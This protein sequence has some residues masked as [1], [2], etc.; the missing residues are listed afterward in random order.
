MLN[1]RT[2]DP[3]LLERVKSWQDDPGWQEFY[4][5]YAPMI[6]SHARRS[7][8]SHEEAQDVL[9]TTML[10]VATYIPRFEYDRT[11]CK[12]RTWLNQIVNQ[13]VIAIWHDRRKV[14]LPEQ[15]RN[16]LGA[17]VGCLSNPGDDPGV[18]TEHEHSM[19]QVCLARTRLAVKPEHWQ[20]FEATVIEGLG[21]REVAQRYD[22]S[23]ANVWV[24]RHRL[25]RRLRLEWQALLQEPFNQ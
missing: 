3:E 19:L 4:A 18:Q 24:I 17:L 14:N 6:E 1:V 2:T 16:E 22:T 21:G 12:F 9:Q 8:L 20:I 13:R 10:K 23:L 15:V 25:V 11:V 7:G 5:R